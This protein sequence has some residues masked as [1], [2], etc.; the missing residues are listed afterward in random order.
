MAGCIIGINAD[1]SPDAICIE[2]CRQRSWRGVFGFLSPAGALRQ[3]SVM[4]RAR[5]PGAVAFKIVS[6]PHITPYM[7]SIGP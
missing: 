5:S 3:I 4:A 2:P 1:R 7:I 6:A